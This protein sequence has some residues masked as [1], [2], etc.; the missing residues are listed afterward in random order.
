MTHHLRAGT[1]LPSGS[2]L[3]ESIPLLP[4][5]VERRPLI[6]RRMAKRKRSLWARGT[7]DRLPQLLNPRSERG[8]KHAPRSPERHHANV[9]VITLLVC[10]LNLS[11]QQSSLFVFR[12][13][14]GGEKREFSM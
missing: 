8:L 10:I 6:Q 7:P 11:K 4:E 1:G 5:R 12:G 14:I 9:H 3:N 2:G 13:N